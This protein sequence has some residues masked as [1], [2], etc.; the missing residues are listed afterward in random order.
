MY[1]DGTSKSKQ[2]PGPNRLA[3][4]A[5]LTP[6]PGGLAAEKLD[7]FN[8]EPV[9]VSSAA[10]KKFRDAFSCQLFFL[11]GQI[12]HHAVSFITRSMAACILIPKNWSRKHGK[13][14]SRN[15]VPGLS[16]RH[17]NKTGRPHVRDTAI[18]SAPRLK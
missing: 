17:P 16:F 13:C 2:I 7:A 10:R 18:G 8:H 15:F 14:V 9:F 6:A 4:H 11:R 1:L 3:L 12:D 5:G